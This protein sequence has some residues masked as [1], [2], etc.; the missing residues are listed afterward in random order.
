M[1]A[2]QEVNAAAIAERHGRWQKLNFGKTLIY[3]WV[4]LVVV[5]PTVDHIYE[6]RQM[7]RP[8]ICQV[9]ALGF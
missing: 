2:S 6:D 5:C 4:L 3:Q 9:S 1:A 8:I 7:V